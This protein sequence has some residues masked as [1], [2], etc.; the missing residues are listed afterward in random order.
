M[1][2]RPR[3]TEVVV[4]PAPAADHASGLLGFLRF[5][6]DD[7]LAV[8]CV[9]LRRT[10]AGRLTL[11]WPDRRD[12]SGGRRFPVRPQDERARLA[13]EAAVFEALDLPAE[14]RS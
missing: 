7:W 12:Q 9:N 10:R 5:K 14:Y 2:T 4:S 3:I 6:V 11:A 1:T 13:L 8:D